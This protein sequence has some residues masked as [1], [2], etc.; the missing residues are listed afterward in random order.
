[1]LNV[2]YFIGSGHTE[3]DSKLLAYMCLFGFGDRL[4]YLNESWY[5]KGSQKMGQLRTWMVVL[6]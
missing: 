5:F 4:T 2:F 3:N 1:M 6:W